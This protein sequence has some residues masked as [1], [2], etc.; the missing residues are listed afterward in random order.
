MY[1]QYLL[2]LKKG[3]ITELK[4]KGVHMWVMKEKQG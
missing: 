2:I 1:T 4:K 3:R